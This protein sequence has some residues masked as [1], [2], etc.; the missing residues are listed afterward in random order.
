MQ[1]CFLDTSVLTNILDVPGKNEQREAV[2]REFMQRRTGGWQLVLPLTAVIETGNHI[3]QVANGHARR[4]CAGL[5]TAMLGQVIEGRAPFVLHEMG[6]DAAFLDAL[7]AGAA[8]A[9][10]L[11]EHLAT[12]FMGCGDLAI[13]V[14][15]D[16]YRA[17]V[18]R[19]S[20]VEV[21]TLDAGL[22]A[23]P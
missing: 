11:S 18:A 1:V 23:Y 10:P 3:A 22:Q 19:G 4:T 8:T 14:E 13:L 2:V 16:R 6:W 9:T 5:F 7:V 15:R 17:R 12:A 20:L 21:W